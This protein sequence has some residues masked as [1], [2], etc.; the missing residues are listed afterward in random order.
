MESDCGKPVHPRPNF[1][2]DLEFHS[3]SHHTHAEK[4]KPVE[5]NLCFGG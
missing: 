3:M 1:L 4:R 2:L 5:S